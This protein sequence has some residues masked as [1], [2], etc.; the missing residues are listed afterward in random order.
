MSPNH[1]IEQKTNKWFKIKQQYFGANDIAAILEHGFN[2]GSHVIDQKV[3]RKTPEHTVAATSRM[4]KGSRYESVARKLCEQRNNITIHETGLR[5]HRDYS[6]I[7][8]SPDGLAHTGIGG[9]PHLTEFKVRATLD[10]LVPVKY[11]MQMQI[12]MEVWDIDNCLYC[13]NQILETT[14][15]QYAQLTTEHK[16]ILIESDKT[17]YWVLTDCYE[18]M[19]SRDREWFAS[20]LPHVTKT[21]DLVEYE[22]NENKPNTRLKYQRKRRAPVEIVEEMNKRRKYNQD[23]ASYIPSSISNWVLKDPLLDWLNLYENPEKKDGDTRFSLRRFIGIK[24]GMFKTTVINYITR[25][26]PTQSLDIDQLNLQTTVPSYLKEDNRYTISYEGFQRTLDAI[27]NNV[28]I[29]L[30]PHLASANFSLKGKGD[31]LVHRNFINEML[32][33]SPIVNVNMCPYYLVSIKFST[34]NLRADGQHLLSNSKQN[35]YKGH[36][37]FLNRC[38]CSMTETRENT[39]CYIIGRKYD[40]KSKGKTYKI[41]NA[42]DKIGIVDFKGVDAPYVASVDEA[43]AWLDRVSSADAATWDPN[44]PGEIIELYPNMKND[45]DYPW[46]NRKKDIA[47]KIGEITLMYYCSPAARQYAHDRGIFD[48]RDLTPNSIKTNGELTISRIMNMVDNNNDE[49]VHG[50]DSI[51]FHTID[52]LPKVEFYVDFETTN[53]LND[54]F[55]TFPEANGCAI[56]FLIGCVSVN[57][58]TGERKFTSYTVDRLTPQSEKQSIETWLSDMERDLID[59]GGE[60]DD[61]VMYHWGNA[62]NWMLR[63]ACQKY[64]IEHNIVLVDLCKEFKEAGVVIPNQFGYGLKEIAP[65]M[66]EHG[67]ITTMWQD[68]YEGTQVMAAAW[69]ADELCASAKYQ[70]LSE[71]PHM[72]EIIS[73]NYVDC[74][75][76]EEMVSYVRHKYIFPPADEEIIDTGDV[77]MTHR[78]EISC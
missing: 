57:N 43:V 67:M 72:K 22:R 12:Q 41:T 63:K 58:T 16:G 77:D 9:I 71:V 55:S 32:G 33:V 14:A 42:F 4:A 37:Q 46:H 31:M 20:V 56:I 44:C 8:A 73:Y 27:K 15:E 13:D 49:C 74:K 65:L 53:D 7:T 21:W 75:V 47:A 10:H 29:I 38:L 54:N 45:R 50:F 69:E 60:N 66:Y 70:C 68:G 5:F 78:Q 6:Y 25:K 3:Y 51:F 61:M 19:I 59:A 24:A 35:V 34:I 23:K 17:Y 52:N 1:E 36:L 30:N 26:Y 2:D 62:E 18:Q 64:G 11:W 48:W 40:Y 76:M 39:N 28:Q